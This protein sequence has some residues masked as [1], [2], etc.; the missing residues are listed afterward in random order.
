M[1]ITR[2]NFA[3]ISIGFEQIH[4]LHLLTS[5][6]YVATVCANELTGITRGW[7]PGKTASEDEPRFVSSTSTPYGGLKNE[8]EKGKKKIN[9]RFW[10]LNVSQFQAGRGRW[11]CLVGKTS[12]QMRT[13]E[14]RMG[15]EPRGIVFGDS[16]FSRRRQSTSRTLDLEMDGVHHYAMW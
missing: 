11:L 14:Q 1:R 9:I 6:A 16:P 12:F 2:A 3:L 7:E 10:S 15:P 8:R 5:S 4:H 13:L